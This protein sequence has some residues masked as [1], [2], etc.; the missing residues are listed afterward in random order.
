MQR[1]FPGE[2]EGISGL[3]NRPLAKIQIY[4][5]NP[6]KKRGFKECCHKSNQPARGRQFTDNP[7]IHKL[8]VF[9]GAK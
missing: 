2:S 3:H 4:P 9:L 8:L 1:G 7:K 5:P 6:L